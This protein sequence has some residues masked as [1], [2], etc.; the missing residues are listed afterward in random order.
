MG[1][2]AMLERQISTE[3]EIA[4]SAEH[5]FHILTD[6]GSYR[7]W[8]PFIPNIDGKPMLGDGLVVTISPPGKKPMSFKPSIISIVPNRKLCWLGRVVCA[9]VF[10]G[11]H[12]FEIEESG[13]RLVRLKQYET[14]TGLLVPLLWRTLEGPTTKGFQLM[15]EAL[16][17]RSHELFTEAA[18]A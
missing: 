11:H 9:G 10:D 16:V 7:E 15:N 17:K 2:G 18:A 5:V 12:C 4:D 3:I 6:F 8:N 1:T 13:D 14:F